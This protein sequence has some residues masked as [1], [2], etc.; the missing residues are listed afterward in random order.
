[1]GWYLAS[2]LQDFTG[3]AHCYGG[4]KLCRLFCTTQVV[5]LLYEY[6]ARATQYWCL[7][8][9]IFEVIYGVL[10]L[11]CIIK[12]ARNC[13]DFVLPR[14][15]FLVLISCSSYWT[16]DEKSRN[17]LVFMERNFWGSI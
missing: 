13:V 2:I 9:F 8:G 16:E 1:M 6:H 3:D 15:Y 4:Q 11:I 14:S 5:S 17:L 7:Y 10:S 12:G